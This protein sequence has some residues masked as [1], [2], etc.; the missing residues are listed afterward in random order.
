VL[1]D[2]ALNSAIGNEPQFLPVSLHQ[3]VQG[4]ILASSQLRHVQPVM[5]IGIVMAHE[6]ESDMPSA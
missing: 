4:R 5:L 2:G 1:F 3:V 6:S